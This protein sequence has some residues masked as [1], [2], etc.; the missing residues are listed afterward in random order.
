METYD[1]LEPP[2]F[3]YCRR[4]SSSLQQHRERELVN[5]HWWTAAAARERPGSPA[6]LCG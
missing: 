1:N 5:P 4:W 2:R 3:C 6:G